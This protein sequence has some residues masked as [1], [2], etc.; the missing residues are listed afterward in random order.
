MEGEE[1]GEKKEPAAK[2]EEDREVE[3]G[4]IEDKAED[5]E[6]FYDKTKSFFDSI[7]CEALERNKN[8]KGRPDWKAEK[9]LNK[10]TF[11]VAGPR[12]GFRGPRGYGGR[13]GYYRGGRGGG[14]GGYG[15]RGG[16]GGGYNSKFELIDSLKTCSYKYLFLQ[17]MVSIT[18]AITIV[19]EVVVVDIHVII[20]TIGVIGEMVVVAT[21]T[22]TTTTLNNNHQCSSNLNLPRRIKPIGTK[23]LPQTI[24]SHPLSPPSVLSFVIGHPI[25]SS[26]Y[27]M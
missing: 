25:I 6:V 27:L 14:G 1:E 21:T 26:P 17:I 12:G 22:I 9:K 15:G 8:N 7:S 11:G 24:L 23:A 2:P 10:E 16:Y 19:T 4:E 20:E 3:E 5:P 13:G 18:T